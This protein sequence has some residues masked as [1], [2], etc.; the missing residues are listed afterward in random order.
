MQREVLLELAE[1][2]TITVDQYA[3]FGRYLS[4]SGRT[5]R[6]QTYDLLRGAGWVR[7]G[8]ITEAGRQVLKKPEKKK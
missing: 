4:G 2:S 3:G 8:R 6:K 1:G 7:G 5:V